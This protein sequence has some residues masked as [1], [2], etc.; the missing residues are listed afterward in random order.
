[1]T[2]RNLIA[3]SLALMLAAW[4]AAAAL[5]QS[6]G[7]TL[8]QPVPPAHENLANVRALPLSRL[9]ALCGDVKKLL[10]LDGELGKRALTQDDLYVVSN[11]TKCLAATAAI[12]D[13]IRVMSAIS[14]Q[15]VVCMPDGVKDE[16]LL[17]GLLSWLEKLD[18]K[19][20]DDVFRRSTPLV[21]IAYIR[22]FHPCAAGH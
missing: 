4:P 2:H 7:L 17:Q 22:Q 3:L 6:N 19:D 8:D 1:M 13:T 20:G 15:P 5:E 10:V 12:F 18:Q 14:D 16:E 9:L 11:G 21:F